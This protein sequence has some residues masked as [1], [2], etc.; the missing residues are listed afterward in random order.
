[1]SVEHHHHSDDQELLLEVSA[2]FPL[3]NFSKTHFLHE[4][5][6][7]GLAHAFPAFVLKHLLGFLVGTL[8]GLQKILVVLN[9]AP[10]A[11]P[12]VEKLE[13]LVELLLCRL[14]LGG[15]LDSLTT[16]V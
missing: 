9:H 16:S 11:G 5:F 4:E 2:N 1:M 7:D 14:L 12:R 15:L 13:L 10:E 6:L 3:N 8:D